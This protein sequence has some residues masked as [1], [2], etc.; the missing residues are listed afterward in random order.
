[1]STSMAPQRLYEA[2]RCDRR[3][4]LRPDNAGSHK[5]SMLGKLQVWRHASCGDDRTIDRT[6]T[7]SITICFEIQSQKML[8]G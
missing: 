7:T 8:Y 1:L 3:S 4:A 5:D 6:I 2:K